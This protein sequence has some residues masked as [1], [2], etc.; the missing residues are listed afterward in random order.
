MVQKILSMEKLVCMYTSG[1]R[2]G[3]GAGGGG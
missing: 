3:G 1:C 2:V